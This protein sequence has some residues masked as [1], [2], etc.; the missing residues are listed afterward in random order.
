MTMIP[1]MKENISGFGKEGC[2]MKKTVWK[3]TGK[4]G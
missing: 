2:V 1:P 4:K 3:A